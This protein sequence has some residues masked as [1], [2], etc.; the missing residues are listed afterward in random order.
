MNGNLNK[1]NS[2]SKLLVAVLAM[3]LI[4]VGAAV[5][6]SD[7]VNADGEE[8]VETD[9][10]VAMIGNT[11]Y[12]DIDT[13]IDAAQVATTDAGKV[14][15]LTANVTISSTEN[16]TGITINCG[17]HDLTF[18]GSTAISITGGTIN[19]TGLGTLK[20]TSGG[21]GDRIVNV[22][23]TVTFNGTVFNS[24]YTAITDSNTS[25]KGSYAY[26]LIQTAGSSNVTFNECQ[27]N[28]TQPEHSDYSDWGAIFDNS[29][30]MTLKDCTIQGQGKI[31]YI[32]SNGTLTLDG[33][34]AY[35]QLVGTDK[36]VDLK[37]FS[38][39]NNGRFLGTFYGWGFNDSSYSNAEEGNHP[40][41]SQD[42][43][44]VTFNDTRGEGQQ[45]PIDFG[46]FYKGNDTNSVANGTTSVATTPEVEYEPDV[47]NITITQDGNPTISGTIATS[48]TTPYTASTI[49]K[50]V[51]VNPG[52]VL[53]IAG[54]VEVQGYFNL[55]GTI[56]SGTTVA[57]VNVTS[58]AEFTAY[59]GAYLGNNVTILGDG[60]IDLSAALYTGEWNQDIVSDITLSQIQRVVINDTI[61]VY[62]GRTFEILG[63][64]VIEEGATI[65]IQPGAVLKIG[66]TATKITATGM[67]VN[68]TI[69]VEGN[70]TS[71]G[72]IK[73]EE[74]QEVTIGGSILSEGLIDIS[75]KVTVENGGTIEVME[76]DNSKLTVDEG[77]TIENSGVLTI[78][79]KFYTP[80]ISNKGTV[81]LD[82]AIL[83]FTGVTKK[84]VNINL[85]GDGAVVQ[86][87][88]V[89]APTAGVLRIQ[90]NGLVFETDRNGDPVAGEFIPD[91]AGDSNAVHIDFLSN[92]SGVRGLTVTES[93][94]SVREN[95]DTLYSNSMYISGTVNVE[96]DDE[97]AKVNIDLRGMGR[98]DADAGGL[99]IDAES[100][101]TLGKNV[102]MDLVNGIMY[103]NGTFTATSEGAGLT[104]LDTTDIYVDGMIT[105]EGAG[106]EP[107]MNAFH[108]EGT[109]ETADY[110][111]Y[112][113]LPVALENSTDIR[114]LGNVTVLEDATI[115]DG[116]RLTAAST[117]TTPVMNIGDED[118][119]DVIV[120]VANGGSIRNGTVNVYATLVFENNSRDN[121]VGNDGSGISSD[122]VINADPAR[123]Y[124]NIYTALADAQDE[125]VT[126]SNKW[127]V[128]L[129][130]DITVPETVTLVVPAGA[131]LNIY[132]AVTLTVDGIL[133]NSGTIQNVDDPDETDD[134]T[135]A[136]FN[137]EVNGEPNTDAAAI[138]VNGAFMSL[139]EIPFDTVGATQG[140]YIPGA[141]YQIIDSNGAWY[142][143]T[144]IEQAATVSGDVNNGLIDIKGEVET[145]DV[146]FTGDEDMP[147]TVSVIGDLT[148]GT[149]TLSDAT[150]EV[151]TTGSYTGSVANTA[152]SV[153]LTNVKNVT[154]Q[155]TVDDDEASTV[156]LVIN[157]TPVAADADADSA[158]SIATGTVNAGAQ[159]TVNTNIGGTVTQI[160]DEFTVASGAQL[161][162]DNA[163]FTADEIS[164]DGTLYAVN[165]G[166]VTVDTLT[167]RGTFTV[168]ANDT[169]NHI[170]AGVADIEKLYIGIALDDEDGT[171]VDASAATVTAD[172]LGS[173]L[174]TVFV[175]AESTFDGKL[176][177]TMDHTEFYVEDALWMTVYTNDR[178][179][180]RDADTTEY[181]QTI[182]NY[183]FVPGDLQS[184]AFV[185][186]MNADGKDVPIGT[187]VGK[188]GY[189][190]VYANIDYNVYGVVITVDNSIGSVAIDGQLLTYDYTLG[191]YIIPGDDP[192][193]TAG[194]HTV[195]YTLAAGYEGTPTLASNG[196]N[197]SVSGM[198]FTLSGDFLKS[199]GTPNINYLTLGG[200][201]YS[202]NTVVI[203]GGNGGS[204]D[205]GLT[206]YLL[207]V[208][209]ILIVIMAIIVA[210]RLMRS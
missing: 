111:Y 42:N 156:L 78:S 92:G 86:I 169:A 17:P 121:R 50:N 74:A 47:E 73:V 2:R 4:V 165:G 7:S 83:D 124:T 116:T 136:G 138:V 190:Q 39:L 115:P 147:L 94:T 46:Q 35:L 173:R 114:F 100:S 193:L 67:T 37:N 21:Y 176:T 140:Y 66:D 52:V 13:A 89:T 146:A 75:S 192:L 120:T 127:D 143:V 131:T 64:L 183:N 77:L 123:T 171:Y 101:V 203:D 68:G 62:S 161:T 122:V 31:N 184:S 158:V 40:D 9:T 128:K 194:Q 118:N 51:T 195:T 177:Q 160:V 38:L 33:T 71:Y 44:S 159:L 189:E 48:N 164:V 139:N 132:D 25:D 90:D 1:T 125:T 14:I 187:E 174:S 88:S 172:N 79:S 135:P 198:N 80:G 93:V 105:V 61:T 54:D 85:V 36:T 20:N 27:F 41:A 34:Q 22:N 56:D 168:A 113:T 106:A 145:S 11:P 23:G 162:V 153:D 188:P 19:G 28:S 5:A 87:D 26:Y 206:D 57:E 91:T 98:T 157:G 155:G 96:S 209:V 141:Y 45:T 58:G 107:G 208:L 65:I 110:D 6:V 166:K 163:N 137:P 144:P 97:N 191:G 210:L 129:N 59:A 186:W 63:E 55:Y 200:A 170:T 142:Y 185:S 201:T 133:R 126:L 102:T 179:N 18:S 112:T 149:V 150:L 175:S 95:G 180:I 99:Y 119:R 178:L 81:T 108:Y 10:N 3:F 130:E 70:Q 12:T 53:T 181:G 16:L 199:D 15:D 29:S 202:G 82:H 84:Q 72:T 109:G 8:P 134:Q 154:V 196:T 76:G 204:S 103:V 30:A 197:V 151:E 182:T 152:G 148:A 24:E 117:A 167:V 205:M 32:V 43:V 207:I 49:F 60:D 69:E 104:S